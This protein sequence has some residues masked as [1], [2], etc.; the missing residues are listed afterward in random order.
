M[1]IVTV[2]VGDFF[3]FS[4]NKSMTE[5]LKDSLMAKFKTKDN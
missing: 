4:N 2:F 3:I 1:I 5:D